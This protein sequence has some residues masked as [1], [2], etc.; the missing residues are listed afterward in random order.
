MINSGLLRKK[1]KLVNVSSFFIFLIS[2]LIILCVFPTFCQFFFN[3]VAKPMNFD[4][5]I[6]KLMENYGK[7]K[8]F[9]TFSSASLRKTQG[10]LEKLRK[11][12]ETWKNDKNMIK[13]M[14]KKWKR[15]KKFETFTIFDC[16]RSSSEFIMFLSCFYRFFKSI[17]FHFPRK[18]RKMNKHFQ[19]MMKND[20]KVIKND[21]N[22]KHSSF[23]VFSSPAR[24][25]CE[26]EGRSARQGMFARGV[27]GEVCGDVWG[28]VCQGRSARGELPGRYGRPGEAR[29]G[30]PGL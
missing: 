10:F 21:K 5:R 24:E 26:A 16:F 30:L 18:Q 25:V 17:F 28:E 15:W 1:S 19:K 7:L 29:G 22:S 2:F 13:K 12:K 8:D 11:M 6:E 3:F 14:I 4:L 23:L 9:S 20:K 27:L